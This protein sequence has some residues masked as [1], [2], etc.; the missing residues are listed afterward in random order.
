LHYDDDEGC[1]D[2]N[3]VGA[4]LLELDQKDRA[5]FFAVYEY[6]EDRI[7]AEELARTE[8]PEF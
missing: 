6:A 2:L 4:R 7:K 5:D 8:E 1:C 3:T